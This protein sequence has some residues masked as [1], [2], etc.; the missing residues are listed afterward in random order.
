M[1]SSAL[2]PPAEGVGGMRPD[3]GLTFV[4]GSCDGE[5]VNGGTG[6]ATAGFGEEIGM[7]EEEGGSKEVE[8]CK[9]RDS[10]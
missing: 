7:A 5:V 6:A 2:E 10:A 8:A 1:L 9:V 4:D 3:S